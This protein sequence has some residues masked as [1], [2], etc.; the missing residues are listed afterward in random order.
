MMYRYHDV[1]TVQIDTCRWLLDHRCY[2][3][4]KNDANSNVLLMIRGKPGSGKSTAMKRAYMRAKDMARANDAVLGF[5][6]NSRGVSIET[7]LEGFLR[8]VLHQLF[9]NRR[10]DASNAVADWKEKSRSIRSGWAWT[11]GELQSMFMTAILN[12]EVAITIFVDALDECESTSAARKLLKLLSSLA[13]S[14]ATGSCQARLKICVSS[15]HYPNVG[16]AE[17]LQIIVEASNEPDIMSYVKASLQQVPVENNALS[18]KITSRSE[19]IFLWA[20]LVLEKIREAIDDGEPR[21]RL[22]EIID[23]VPQ[24]LEELFQNLIESIPQE[25]RERCKLVIWWVLFAKR[26]LQL[27]EL[28]DALAFRQC[29]ST[30]GK[31]KESKE[32]I[33]PAQL[34]RL[35]AKWTMGLVDAV[36]NQGPDRSTGE[37]MS[38][39]RVQFIHES[40]REYILAQQAVPNPRS[41]ATWSAVGPAHNALAL[42]CFNYIKAVCSAAQ[43]FGFDNNDFRQ[44]PVIHKP[45][46][47]FVDYATKFGFEHA[48]LAEA[49]GLP[50]SYLFER[51]TNATSRL[52]LWWNTFAVIFAN[53]HRSK[54]WRHQSEDHWSRFI[55]SQITFACAFRLDSWIQSLLAGEGSLVNKN[56]LSEALCVVATTKNEKTL[57]LLLQ[58]GADVNY[59]KPSFG[60]PL[61]LSLLHGRDDFVPILLAHGASVHKGVRDHSPVVT[62]TLHSSLSSLHLILSRDASLTERE[63]Q[64][65]LDRNV[66]HSPGI[67]ALQAA[68][69]REFSFMEALLDAA[70]HQEVAFEYYMEAHHSATSDQKP[71]HARA[72]ESAIKRRFQDRSLWCIHVKTLNGKMIEIGVLANAR[73]YDLKKLLEAREGPPPDQIFLSNGRRIFRDDEVLCECVFGKGSTIHM[74]PRMRWGGQF[75][76][77]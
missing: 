20:F 64:G 60:S 18:E 77:G 24:R 4:W 46:G 43:P 21:A 54:R 45:T 67:H 71:Q 11:E 17:P 5:F 16:V 55:A 14:Q 38:S 28:R 2:Q 37:T 8:S 25:E 41:V 7:K 34:R 59:N 69:Q 15:R 48:E 72:L 30:Y 62:A 31:Y 47:A 39:F 73:I 58:S 9:R 13:E 40:V 52:P 6:F 51:N 27:S 65:W 50:Q 44:E 74:L 33:N 66:F 42:S 23:L 22:Y 36:G 10:N 26:P 19:G 3:S 32:F 70:G 12:S 68:A 75:S 53:H 63:Q 76:G 61:T 29:Y 56:D 1:D 49:S 35:L 57:V